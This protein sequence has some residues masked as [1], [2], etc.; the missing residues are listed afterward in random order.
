MYEPRLAA[1]PDTQRNQRT[2]VA[3]ARPEVSSGTVDRA[4]ALFNALGDPTRLRLYYLI[5]NPDNGS[6]CCYELASA[7]GVSAPTITHHMKKLTAAGLV[8]R[9]QHGKWAHFRAEPR[10]FA[11]VQAAV[12][13]CCLRRQTSMNQPQSASVPAMYA[14]T[15][16]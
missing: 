11:A 15:G 5:A 7:L 13:S 1:K 8:E 2:P 9:T 12:S 3:V 14:D 6:V 16:A 4:A 10:N